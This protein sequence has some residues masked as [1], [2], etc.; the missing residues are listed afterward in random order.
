[1]PSLVDM[2]QEALLGEALDL[3]GRVVVVTGA[4]SGIGEAVALGLARLGMKVVGV[5]RRAAEL[6]RVAEV[7]AESNLTFATH[8]ADVTDEAQLD[9][10]MSTAVELFGSVH[11]VVANAGIAVVEPAMDVSADDFR[12]V[13]ETNL[14]GAFL[15]A[16]SAARRMDSG[17]SVV[18]TSSSF[19]KRGFNDWSSY[20]ASKAGVSMLTE[21]L[22]KEW[23]SRGI[24]VN[25]V[26]PTATLT[27]VN[28]ALFEDEAFSSAVVAGIPAGRIL[29]AAELLLPIAFLL[30][31]RNQMLIGQTL[32]VDGGQ[33]L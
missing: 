10:A 13:L 33:A 31:P 18:F 21:T 8:Q 29:Q 15:T 1:M 3:A 27:A 23:I 17:G 30:S 11:S 20:N 32:F 4:T 6:D 12:S 9:S 26:A 14:T 2:K 7:A 5:A 24:R 25:A 16:R 19:A 28:A 22:A